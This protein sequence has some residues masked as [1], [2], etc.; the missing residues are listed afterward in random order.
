MKNFGAL[1][2]SPRSGKFVS[3]SMLNYFGTEKVVPFQ[4]PR[5]GKF[6]SDARAY[7]L[8]HCRFGFQSPR[9]GKFVSDI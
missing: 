2:Q 1:F 9:S 5:S 8:F 4:S 6:V 3:D 7:L